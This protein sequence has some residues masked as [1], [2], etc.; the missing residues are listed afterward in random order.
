MHDFLLVQ[1]STS[2]RDLDKDQSSLA[3]PEGL[4]FF[5]HIEELPAETQLSDDIVI[6][7][8]LIDM[9]HF[10]DVGVVELLQDIK[11]IEKEGLNFTVL[12]AVDDLDCPELACES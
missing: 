6:I 4:D 3:F 5:E 8:F 1:I 9:E 2:R 7:E 11:L 12:L 10:E